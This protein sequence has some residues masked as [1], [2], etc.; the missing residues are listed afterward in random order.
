MVLSSTTNTCIQKVVR[1]Q[2]KYVFYLILLLV[3]VYVYKVEKRLKY[4]TYIFCI[5]R[6]IVL[7]FDNLRTAHRFNDKPDF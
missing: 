2:T 6:A 1:I 4:K 7:F 5:T 3:K